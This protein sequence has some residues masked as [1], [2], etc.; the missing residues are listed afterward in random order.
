MI[1][2]KIIKCNDE[3]L[4][5]SN[6]CTYSLSPS[7]S[8]PHCYHLFS[9]ELNG[10]CLFETEPIN[11][12]IK[13]IIDNNL[14]ISNDLLKN[15]NGIIFSDIVKIITTKI[16]NI[17]KINSNHDDTII[18]D[19]YNNNNIKLQIPDVIKNKLQSYNFNL[20][21]AKLL[22]NFNIHGEENIH[23]F[24]HLCDITICEERINIFL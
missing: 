17:I 11:I 16:I 8:I 10:I 24:L 7:M 23:I 9:Y 3:G 5:F 19:I 13:S 20:A 18:C 6:L 21:N 14:I 22:W 15:H 4:E 2:P 12:N 1:I